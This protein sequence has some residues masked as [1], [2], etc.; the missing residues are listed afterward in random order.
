MRP[1][2]QHEFE[3]IRSCL[4]IRSHLLQIKLYFVWES[5]IYRF[6]TA[7]IAIMLLFLYFFFF[8]RYFY[9]LIHFI[10]FLNVFN[11]SDNTYF[12]LCKMFG[13]IIIWT[14]CFS[15]YNGIYYWL[16]L[17]LN[18]GDINNLITNFLSFKF[19][20]FMGLFYF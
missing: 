1:F 7:L 3:D 9:L 20:F 19:C 6:L 13:H 2:I 11:V 5:F 17:F 18:R 8:F 12:E 16:F 4:L 14:V 15:I 10:F